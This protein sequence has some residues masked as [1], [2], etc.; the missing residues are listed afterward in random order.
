MKRKERTRTAS[1]VRESPERERLGKKFRG[2]LESFPDAVVIMKR[3]GEIV[4]VN[5]QAE[6]MFGFSREELLGL[7][8]EILIPPRPGEKYPAYREGFLGNPQVRLTAAGL[9]LFGRRKNGR[10]SLTFNGV[11]GNLAIRLAIRDFLAGKDYEVMGTD[12]CE[13]ATVK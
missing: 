9:E 5:V 6:E 11:P 1:A 3:S 12:S 13:G 4:L 2:L 8:V 7:P 10:E